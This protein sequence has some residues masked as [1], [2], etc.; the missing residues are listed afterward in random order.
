MPALYLAKPFISYEY[1][2]RLHSEDAA[3]AGAL[4]RHVRNVALDPLGTA[5][6]LL[7]MTHKRI[8]AERK[9]PSIVVRPKASIYSL[10]FN[11]EQEPNR[12]SRIRLLAERDQLGMQRI[13]VDWRPTSGDLR[14]ARE[15]VRALA[16]DLEASGCGHLLHDPDAVETH[17]LRDGTLGG[18]HIGI[19]RMAASPSQ[20]VVDADCRVHG[21]RN[22][23]VAGSSVFATSSQAN[24]T[25]TI[26]A[27]ALAGR[28]S[29][30][31][32]GMRCCR[33]GASLARARG[34]SHDSCGSRR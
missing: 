8:F 31:A 25:L 23:Y 16:E 20:G 6:F 32:L 5:G 10:E 4:V 3:S 14:T 12:D 7:H 2:K 29:A 30:A 1:R 26:A 15:A 13:S 22:L 28:P 17:A 33:G 19:T 18:H 11:S 21:L 27:L 24:P 9:F 34:R